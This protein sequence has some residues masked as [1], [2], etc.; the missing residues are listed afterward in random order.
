LER[1]IGEELLDLGMREASVGPEINARYLTI[2]AR[3]EQIQNFVPSVG[4]VNIAGAQSA[5]FRISELIEHEEAM[6]KVQ[7]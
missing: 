3:Y 7:V 5:G 1:C 4:A 6:T 2:I